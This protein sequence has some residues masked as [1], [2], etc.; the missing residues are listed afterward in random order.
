MCLPDLEKQ[1]ACKACG[2]EGAD[3]RPDFD[4]DTPPI[5]MA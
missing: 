5:A 4:Q 1:L 2:T 3:V